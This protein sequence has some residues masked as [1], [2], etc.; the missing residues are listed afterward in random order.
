MFP[1]SR[2]TRDIRYGGAG[3]EVHGKALG[4]AMTVTF[5]LNGQPFTALNGEP[6]FSFSEAVSLRVMCAS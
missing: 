3:F 4:T 6:A 5:E 1:D 2:I